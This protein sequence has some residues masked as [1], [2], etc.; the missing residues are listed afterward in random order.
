MF[1]NT[2]EV[3]DSMSMNEGKRNSIRDTATLYGQYIDKLFVVASRKVDELNRIKRDTIE[4]V[5]LQKIKTNKDNVAIGNI[6]KKRITGMLLTFVVTD[7]YDHE[8]DFKGT[9]VWKVTRN[10]IETFKYT[11]ILP[12]QVIIKFLNT[13]GQRQTYG[14]IDTFTQHDGFFGRENW[15]LCKACLCKY[16]LELSV[17]CPSCGS[18]ASGVDVAALTATA[19]KEMDSVFKA[20]GLDGFYKSMEKVT[21]NSFS[22][23]INVVNQAIK[24][25]EMRNAMIAKL[26]NQS[27]QT[28]AKQTE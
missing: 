25:R 7:K 9:D 6:L 8:Q 27:Q 22:F 26:V 3:N 17:D 21:L 20:T 4:R 2:N 24:R 11:G 5:M 13:D 19:L 12:V 23:P 16:D 14:S 15:T 10:I 1:T 28:T 18:M